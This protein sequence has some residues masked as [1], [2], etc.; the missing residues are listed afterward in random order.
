M[1]TM[2]DH[3]VHDD[4]FDALSARA[5]RECLSVLR[6]RLPPLVPRDRE[7]W[8]DDGLF[9]RGTDRHDDVDVFRSGPSVT[10]VVQGRTGDAGDLRFSLEAPFGEPAF[11]AIAAD[12]AEGLA[13]LADAWEALV[14]IPVR[15]VSHSPRT[16]DVLL[17]DDADRTLDA[18]MRR[19]MARAATAILAHNPRRHELSQVSA[20]APCLAREG[21]IANGRR[22]PTLAAA[23]ERA[24]VAGLP[25]VAV[26]SQSRP[27]SFSAGAL[28]F[29]QPQG[30]LCDGSPTSVMR[31][32]AGLPEVARPLLKAGLV[33]SS[34]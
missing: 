23:L 10:V 34:R 2:P 31:L 33:G 25:N 4:G 13:A 30:E 6:D 14:G 26:L 28:R 11:A 1:T 22:K 24:V 17:R 5:V 27:G 15:R 12:P 16:A 18:A 7:T 3:V 9:L 19:A 8:P 21:A 20:S 29:E 32:V